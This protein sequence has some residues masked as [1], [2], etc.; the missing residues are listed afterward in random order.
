MMADEMAAKRRQAFRQMLDDVEA[1]AEREGYLSL[2][3]V[4]AELDLL[5]ERYSSDS[6]WL[7]ASML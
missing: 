2:D 7:P 5:I 6:T 1:E 3:A 4:A